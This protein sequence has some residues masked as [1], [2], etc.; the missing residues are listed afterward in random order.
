MHASTYFDPEGRHIALCCGL[1]AL[2]TNADQQPV[3]VAGC[4]YT[5]ELDTTLCACGHSKCQASSGDA[6]MSHQKLR[7]NVPRELVFH[8]LALAV[9]QHERPKH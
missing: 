6:A 1:Q 5:L 4:Q 8:V 2:S 3:F 7:G 9:S